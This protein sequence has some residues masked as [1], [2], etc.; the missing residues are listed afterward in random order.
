VALVHRL[1]HRAGARRRQVAD[2][3]LGHVGQEQGDDVAA[4]H[5]PAQRQRRGEAP[6]RL[7]QG[8]VAET[9]IARHDRRVVRTSRL[10]RVPQLDQG[11]EA[12]RAHLRFSTTRAGLPMTRL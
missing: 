10:D 4:P 2:H 9:P 12:L 6:H 5:A 1:H 3:E 7:A 11:A 8:A